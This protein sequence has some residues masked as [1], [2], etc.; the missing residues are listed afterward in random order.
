MGG[1]GDITLSEFMRLTTAFSGFCG[2]WFVQIPLK[3]SAMC[4]VTIIDCISEF[5]AKERAY[6]YLLEQIHKQK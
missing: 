3:D 2:T 6:L 5:D 1:A 4:T